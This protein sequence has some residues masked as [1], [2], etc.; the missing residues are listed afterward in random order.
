MDVLLGKGSWIL[1]LQ[2]GICCQYSSGR[3]GMLSGVDRRVVGAGMRFEGSWIVGLQGGMFC[4]YSSG[5]RYAKWG[6]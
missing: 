5:R 6:G 2:A 1:G 4:Q 3:R